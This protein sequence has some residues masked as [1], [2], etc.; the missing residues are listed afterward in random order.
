MTV[1]RSNSLIALALVGMLAS[2]PA[3]ASGEQGGGEHSEEHHEG[4]HHKYFGSVFL[5]ATKVHDEHE[6]TLG[7]EFGINLN[8]YWSTA[9]LIERSDREKDT[10]LWLAQLELHPTANQRLRFVAGVGRKD[11]SGEEENVG[12]LGI[13]YE[14]PFSGSSFVKPFI[15]RDFIENHDDEDVYGLYVG[16]GF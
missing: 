4:G 12:R 5:G 1:R 13:G 11:P 7:I 15:A 16:R 2:A 8:R 3:N 9:F 14:I 10:T 6:S